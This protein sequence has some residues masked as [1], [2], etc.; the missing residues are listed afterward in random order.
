MR[1][2]LALLGLLMV[3]TSAH[4]EGASVLW[5]AGGETR[6]GAKIRG[7]WHHIRV[8]KALVNVGRRCSTPRQRRTRHA[9]VRI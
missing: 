8:P 9:A 1:V 4:A 6:N 7:S 3:V 2:L 5:V